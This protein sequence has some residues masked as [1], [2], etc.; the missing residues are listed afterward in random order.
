MNQW[1]PIETAPR[2]GTQIIATNGI[3]ISVAAWISDTRGPG[4]SGCIQYPGWIAFAMG[5]EILDE[6]WDTGNGFTMS[7]LDEN[8][9]THWMSLPELPK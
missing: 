2:D 1:Q 6:G 3:S 5:R 8:M 4:V 7:M 9:P